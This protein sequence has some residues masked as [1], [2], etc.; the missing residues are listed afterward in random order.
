MAQRTRVDALHGVTNLMDSAL[1]AAGNL[2]SPALILYG[3]RDE[4]I[5][6]EAIYV[7]LNKLPPPAVSPWR[8]AFYPEGYHLL[9][10]DSRAGE[11]INDIAAWLE[12][13]RAPLPSGR[14]LKRIR[15]EEKLCE[16]PM[17]KE[18]A[19]LNSVQ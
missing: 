16:Q 9:T 10:H 2:Q 6:A 7:L 19:S 4:I 17:P 5:P 18:S 1:A 11:T 12:S 13:R 3:G 8:F 15:A 14:E